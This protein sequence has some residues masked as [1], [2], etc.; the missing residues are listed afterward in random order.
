[1]RNDGTYTQVIEDAMLADARLKRASQD[2]DR[3]NAQL[4]ARIDEMERLINQIN[5]RLDALDALADV[6][7]IDTP[8]PF[9]PAQFVEAA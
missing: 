3:E 1:M 8:I 9:L 6:V 2:Q 7:L 4:K 5:Q